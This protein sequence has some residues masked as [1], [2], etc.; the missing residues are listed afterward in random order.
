VQRAR[1]V[2]L[3]HKK[4]GTEQIARE[5]GCSARNVRKWKA[6]FMAN[7][8]VDALEDGERCGRP[9]EIP[10]A[11]RCALVQIAC[12]RH[13]D[14]SPRVIMREGVFHGPSPWLR[15]LPRPCPHT[16]HMPTLV[17]L[18]QSHRCPTKET[19]MARSQ[20]SHAQGVRLIKMLRRL[21]GRVEGVRLAE[22]LLRHET[23]CARRVGARSG[24]RYLTA[25]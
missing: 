22:R 14:R 18:A 3:A 2:L 5:L 8:R 15:F 9:A 6:R 24:A 7:P 17:N 10:L 19:A 25:P 1:I 4:K 16:S 20:G 11:I 13:I 21:Q 23:G 12:K